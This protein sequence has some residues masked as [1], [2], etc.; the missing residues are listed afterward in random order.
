MNTKNQNQLLKST[1]SA[2]VQ[3]VRASFLVTNCIA[4]AKELFTIGEELILSDAKNICR[5]EAAV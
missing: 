5:E 4:K 2:N 1:T 3:A